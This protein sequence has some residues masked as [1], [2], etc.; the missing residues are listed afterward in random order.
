MEERKAG[1]AG[2]GAGRVELFVRTG[3]FEII[4]VLGF[5]FSILELSNP[6]N[7]CSD[8]KSWSN[9][10]LQKYPKKYPIFIANSAGYFYFR[11]NIKEMHKKLTIFQNQ[12]QNIFWSNACLSKY[13]FFICHC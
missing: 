2:K 9:L 8:Q 1:R 10:I 4:E 12:Q 11:L 3:I 6:I 5:A 13:P 7:P